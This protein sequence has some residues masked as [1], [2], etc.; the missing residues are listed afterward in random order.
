MHR[1]ARKIERYL[2]TQKAGRHS[3]SN[4]QISGKSSEGSEKMSLGKLLQSLPPTP[5]PHLLAWSQKSLVL[6][7]TIFNPQKI[8]QLTK[9]VFI[10]VT[11]VFTK[12]ITRHTAHLSPIKRILVSFCEQGKN[13]HFKG[14]VS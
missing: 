4:H 14:T 9:V 11:H 6:V 5:P 1:N 10:W 2:G 12:I 13:S 7:L 3:I 8:L